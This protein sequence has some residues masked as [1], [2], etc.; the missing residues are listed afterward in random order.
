MFYTVANLKVWLKAARFSYL[1]PA[2]HLLQCTHLVASLDS[3]QEWEDSHL[4][5]SIIRKGLRGLWDRTPYPQPLSLPFTAT[6]A[7]SPATLGS[8]LPHTHAH[9]CPK[10]LSS[11]PFTHSKLSLSIY[12]VPG[13]SPGSRNNP[14]IGRKTSSS[15]GASPLMELIGVWHALTTLGCLFKCHLISVA[16]PD[17]IT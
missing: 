17:R 8:V 9:L 11:D 7:Q 1:L 3:T 6:P 12:Y 5:L 15:K 2:P 16:F 4:H 14:A 13:T 10:Q